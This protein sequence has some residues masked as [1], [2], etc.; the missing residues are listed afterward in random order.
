MIGMA[1]SLKLSLRGL[2]RDLLEQSWVTWELHYVQRTLQTL[3]TLDI[4][5][6]ASGLLS[7]F[8]SRKKM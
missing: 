2:G 5:G 7:V 6:S 8:F 4:Q 1:W 3:A